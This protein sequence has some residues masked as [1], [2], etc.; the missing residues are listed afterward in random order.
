MAAFNPVDVALWSFRR[1]GRDVVK[2]YDSLSPVMQLATGGDMLNFGYWQDGISD[3]VSAQENLCGLAG[4]MAEL[5]GAITLL[6]AGSGLAAP[7]R[8]WKRTYPSLRVCCLNINS[9]QLA[10]G[11]GVPDSSGVWP[12]NATSTELPIADSALD[13]IIALESAQHFRPLAHFASESARALK[14]GG[15]LLLAIPV[16]SSTAASLLRLGILAF[17]WSSEHYTIGQ[18]NSAVQNSGLSI[19][20]ELRIGHRVYEPLAD[21]YVQHRERLRKQILKQYSPL[22]EKILHRSIL[23]MKQLSAEGAIE[24]IVLKAEKVASKKNILEA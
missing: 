15:M 21:Y 7:A 22:V 13:R 1:S 2:L 5:S 12:L 11:M 9:G 6:D 19:S 14:V 3:P 16:V 18:L 24:Y 20:E 4:R 23:K 10:A 8:Y 17:T